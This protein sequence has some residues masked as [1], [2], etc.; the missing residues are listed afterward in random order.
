MPKIKTVR[1]INIIIINYYSNNNYYNHYLL[2]NRSTI[3]LKTINNNR[4]INR[5]SH[6]NYLR[7]YI[8][9]YMN[10]DINITLGKFIYND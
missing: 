5:L 10:Y 7:N 6:F 3:N 9:Y 2:I 1:K 8:G 4:I